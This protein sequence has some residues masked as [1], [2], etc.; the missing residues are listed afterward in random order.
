[1]RYYHDAA[2]PPDEPLPVHVRMGSS[3]FHSAKIDY[4][5]HFVA[6]P[7]HVVTPDTDRCRRCI[8]SAMQLLNG[9]LHL[10]QIRGA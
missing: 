3:S 8:F 5:F 10:F 1:M 6:V 9:T 7:R 4:A 2:A